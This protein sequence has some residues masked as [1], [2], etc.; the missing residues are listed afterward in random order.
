MRRIFK[1]LSAAALLMTIVPP[2]LY[3]QGMIPLAT[4]HT[5]MAVGM[6]IWFITAPLWINEKINRE[7]D[8]S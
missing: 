1:I 6:I 3:F 8:Q 2:V 4:N 7:E 5:I